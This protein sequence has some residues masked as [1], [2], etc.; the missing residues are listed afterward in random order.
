MAFLS[1][2]EANLLEAVSRL[3][4][5]NVFLPERIEC[6]RQ[7]LGDAAVESPRVWSIRAGIE[8]ERANIERM[9]KL[10]EPLADDLHARLK[11]SKS[12][13]SDA[14][15]TLYEDLVLCVLY[16]RYRDD[17]QEA[18]TRMLAHGKSQRVAFYAKFDAD[19]AGYLNVPGVALRG[20]DEIPHLFSAFFQLR[21]AFHHIFRH[22]VGGS[23][24]T[25][26]LRAAIWQ[27]I[28]THNIRRY[29]RSLYD[30][31][32]DIATLIT[33]PTGTGKELV[34]RAIGLSRY[35]P[36]D[37]K[38][39]RFAEDFTGSFHA[40]NL[41]ALSPTLIE[42]ELFGHR[43][44]SFT[45]AVADRA[46]WL[47][48]CE[49]LGT[50]FLDEIGELAG[51]VQVKLLRVLQ[52]RTFQRLGDTETK[53]FHGKI[54]AATNRDLVE[55]IREGRFRE[56]FYYRICSDIICTPSL[57]E[58]LRESPEELRNLVLFL[59]QRT[60]VE[61]TDQLADEV[62]AWINEKLGADYPWPGNI[63][64]LEQCVRNVMIRNEYHP[65]CVAPG[66]PAPGSPAP[67]SDSAAGARGG[68][69]QRLA[70]HIREGALTAEELLRHYCTI[71]Y[72]RTGSY[73]AAARK[74]EIDRRTVKA[75]IDDDL[76]AELTDDGEGERETF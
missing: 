14:E 50:V 17:F 52:S 76:L 26:K 27:S 73:E 29:R 65:Q 23:M 2:S 49:P 62:V 1:D 69:H 43:R 54:I 45:G 31:M 48:V 22:I 58:Q 74:L 30:K 71:V 59:A 61:D 10:I 41:S 13:P 47:E 38:S 36:F 20:L 7:I 21:R 63:R 15:L 46:G 8:N 9:S 64:E 12:P 68:P 55:E 40:L 60:G 51:A 37:P 57:R 42:S 67:G 35:I 56:D 11:Q 18:L 4:Y 53:Q 28:F 16:H 39:Q 75:K 25:A 3:N 33:G 19:A 70:R 72:A 24:A 66:S 32:G 6:E 34:A 44:G 5:C